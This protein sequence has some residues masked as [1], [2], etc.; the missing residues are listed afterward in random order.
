MMELCLAFEGLLAEKEC[1][2]P[3]GDGEESDGHDKDIWKASEG[4]E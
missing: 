3:M 2:D 1:S 4:W